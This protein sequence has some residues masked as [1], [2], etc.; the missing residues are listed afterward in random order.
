M[1]SSKGPFSYLHNPCHGPTDF[2]VREGKR[3]FSRCKCYMTMVKK[4]CLIF[5]LFSPLL[6]E[7]HHS[8][9]RKEGEKKERKSNM[10]TK[11]PS[12]VLFEHILKKKDQDIHFLLHG[13]YSGSTFRLHLVKGPKGFQ[14][15]K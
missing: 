5:I 1:R 13:H 12:T 9:T 14:N 15:A 2:A 7:C 4:R 3:G 11:N 8:Y 6:A 10:Q